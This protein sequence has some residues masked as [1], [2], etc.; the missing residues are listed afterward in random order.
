MEIICINVLDLPIHE[1]E[2]LALLPTSL[3][4]SLRAETRISLEII[5][6]DGM[7]INQVW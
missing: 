1:T 4:H 3:I 5:M 2:I 6:I 7:V